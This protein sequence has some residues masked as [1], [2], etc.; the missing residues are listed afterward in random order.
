MCS[1]C[2]IECLLSCQHEDIL[3]DSLREFC[4]CCIFCTLPSQF[5]NILHGKQTVPDSVI[6]LLNLSLCSEF[7][8]C[9]VIL[10]TFYM[11]TVYCTVVETKCILGIIL[12][13]YNCVTWSERWY[14]YMTVQMC[15]VSIRYIYWS[16]AVTILNTGCSTAI[17]S[18]CSKMRENNKLK[19]LFS[20]VCVCV[21]VCSG[22][23][24]YWQG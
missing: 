22:L 19:Q 23:E 13:V 3:H 15:C 2:N 11:T 1:N 8:C 21:S 10:R 9:H 14:I 4:E 24:Y 20:I 17:Y 16:F 5:E 6:E 7:Y 18:P 12:E